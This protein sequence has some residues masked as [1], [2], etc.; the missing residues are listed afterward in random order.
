M[1][2]VPFFIGFLIAVWPVNMIRSQRDVPWTDDNLFHT[3][4]GRTCFRVQRGLWNVNMPRH[5]WRV[6]KCQEQ[7]A[8]PVPGLRTVHGC[9]IGD[10]PAD[11][12]G[13]Y[14]FELREVA[15]DGFQWAQAQIV[16]SGGLGGSGA[17]VFKWTRGKKSIH[18]YP[19]TYVRTYVCTYVHTYIHT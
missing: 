14:P 6:K 19:H 7:L 1:L 11:P 12:P 18:N 15:Q 10:G 9:G 4:A 13:G 3:E 8:D 16:N 2:D 5:A 17:S